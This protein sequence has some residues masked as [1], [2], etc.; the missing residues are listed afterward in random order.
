M[1]EERN[2]Q[3]DRNML[4]VFRLLATVQVFAGHAAAHLL[5]NRLGP[6]IYQYI[7]FVRG[8]P[9]L[10]ILCGFLAAKS[11]DGQ[12]TKKW[13]VGRAARLL[14]AYWVCVAVNTVIIFSVY[15]M[16]PSFCSGIVYA[17][18]QF[19]G[20]NFYTGSW[21]RGYGV[22]APNGA[23]WTISPQIQFFILAPLIYRLMKK[24]SPPKAAVFIG[25]LT[26][27]SIL[28]SRGGVFLPEVL[29][30]LVGVSVFPYLY[31][32]VFGM[33]AWLFRDR[34]VPA[35]EKFR[36][37]FVA[38]YVLWKLFEINISAAHWLNGIDYNVVTTLLLAC[39]IF[40]FAFRRQWR[41]PA[42]YTYGFYLYHM[43]FVNLA[44]QRGFSSL[45]P[46]ERGVWIL[47]GIIG[48]TLLSAILSKK[49]VEEPAA[50][51]VKRKR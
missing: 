34:L 19:T 44:I 26:G 31:F 27:L 32:L 50:R 16:P 25:G 35:L 30:K 2:K 41:C 9:V 38:A 5:G 46:V 10:L 6:N 37:H 3:Y 12:N 18:T 13:L 49:F 24:M 17:A 28:C 33:A 45:L 15:S 36:W 48:M 7:H 8:V 22:R 4:D 43:V 29:Y 1:S 23:L 47:L 11:L 20:L 21:L 39:V 51:L 14:P 42:D 40:G